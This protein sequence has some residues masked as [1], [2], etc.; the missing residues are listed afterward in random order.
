MRTFWRTLTPAIVR[1]AALVSLEVLLVAV[2]YGATAVSAGM[3]AWMPPLIAILVLAGSAEFLFVGILAAGG[4]VVAA[5][6][7]AL[8]VNARHLP[9][10]M[11]MRHIIG[12]GRS[13][14][15]AAHL[16]NDESVVLGLGQSDRCCARAAFWAGGIGVLLAWP[17]GTVLGVAL[18]GAIADPDA[19]GLDAAFPAIVAALVVPGLRSSGRLTLPILGAAIALAATPFVPAG[20]PPLLALAALLVPL[21]TRLGGRHA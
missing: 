5:V 17:L 15:L 16:M 10:G 6:A 19:I 11:A 2:S 7:A 13:R 21:L 14:F 3:P 12:G 18:G 9:Y 20:L 4:G 1:D 8:V